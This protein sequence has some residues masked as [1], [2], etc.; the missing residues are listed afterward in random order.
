MPQSI[1]VYRVWLPDLWLIL[2]QPINVL[3]IVHL[4]LIIQDVTDTVLYLQ[5]RQTTQ[6]LWGLWAL[7]QMALP[8]IAL[9]HLLKSYSM[10]SPAAWRS[11]I[12]S[13]LWL[14]VTAWQLN[15]HICSQNCH[16][17]W[18][19]SDQ[20]SAFWPAKSCDIC[21]SISSSWNCC[22]LKYT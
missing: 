2:V 19:V 5:W 13:V 8:P 12:I 16:K 4:V 11:L 7:G 21:G 15:C 10:S 3:I 20:S 22:G 17:I 14:T 1:L 18:V 9:H 6:L